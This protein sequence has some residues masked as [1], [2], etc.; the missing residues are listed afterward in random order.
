MGFP[1]EI[2]SP[3]ADSNLLCVVCLNVLEDASWLKCGH[4]FCDGCIEDLRSDSCP[5]C[6]KRDVKKNAL[7]NILIRGLVDNLMVKC[8]EAGGDTSKESSPERTMTET[9]SSANKKQKL[10]VNEKRGCCWTGKLSEWKSHLKNDCDYHP[11]NC[12]VAG[13]PYVGARKEMDQHNRDSMSAH[14]DLMLSSKVNVIRSEIKEEYDEKLRTLEKRLRDEMLNSYLVNVCR[15]WMIRKPD[16]LFDFVMYR[17]KKTPITKLLCGIPGPTR[18][19]W[20]GGIFPVLM[21]FPPGNLGPPKCK[22]PKGFFHV[23]IYASGMV[24]LSDLNTEGDWHP[25]TG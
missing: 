18:T 22:L 20:E 8:C 21:L 4:T 15:Q 6:R 14:M 1:T 12:C 5:T 16:A 9:S 2:F 25:I 3:E 19:P 13:C 17:P 7:P 23:N 10:E 24:R 11:V